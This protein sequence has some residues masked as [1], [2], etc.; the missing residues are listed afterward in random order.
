MKYGCTK[1]AL[2]ILRMGMGTVL[3]SIGGPMGGTSTAL[4]T[5]ADHLSDRRSSLDDT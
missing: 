3:R 2:T 5:Q 1:I 4:A